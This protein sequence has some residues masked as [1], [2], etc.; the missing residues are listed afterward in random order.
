MDKK[1]DEQILEGKIDPKQWK[2]EVERVYKDLDN[3]ERD[4][5]LIKTRG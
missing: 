3:I 1:E 5:Q 2:L 4:L